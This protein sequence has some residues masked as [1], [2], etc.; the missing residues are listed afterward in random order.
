MRRD[1][2]S[3]HDPAEVQRLARTC[4][5]GYLGVTDPDG[6]PRVVPLNFAMHNGSIY[7]HGA[8]EGEKYEAFKRTPKVSFCFVEPFSYLPSYWQAKEHACPAT[9]FFKSVYMRGKGSLVENPDEKA[10]AL[11]ALMDK[12]QPEGGFKSLSVSDPLYETSIRNVGIFKVKPERVDMKI[13]LGQGY[14]D[15]TR[16]KL[17]DHLRERGTELDLQTIAEIECA[18]KSDSP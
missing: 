5:V 13:K 3:V 4:E 7:F 9:I 15:K 1:E 6:Y 18:A 16:Q 10:A 8:Q 14:T 11:Q 2:F 17:I 12:H